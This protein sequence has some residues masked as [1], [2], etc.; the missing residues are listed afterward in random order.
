MSRRLT[1][2]LDSIR[3]PVDPSRPGSSTDDD[4]RHH[5]SFESDQL[6]E[7][8]RAA[9]ERELKREQERL[10]Q[11]EKNWLDSGRWLEEA[12]EDIQLDWEDGGALPFVRPLPKD[13]LPEYNQCV[14]WQ[15]DD[16][17]RAELVLTLKCPR[18]DPE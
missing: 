17:K 15:Y 1:A 3:E 11:N 9:H 10:E 7:E 18:E 14:V 2:T 12:P 4:V 13:E 6:Y 16:N 5:L 8:A